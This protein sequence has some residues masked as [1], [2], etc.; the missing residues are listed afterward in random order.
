LKRR[1]YNKYHIATAIGGEAALEVVEKEQTFA[2]AV[3]DMRMPGLDG[4]EVLKRLRKRSPDTQRIMLT[5][6]IDQETAVNAVNEGSILRFYTKPCSAEALSE[7]ID[8]GIRQ[9]RLITA[10]RDLL[11]KTLAGSVKVLTDVLALAAPNAFRHSA[12]YRDWVRRCATDLGVAHPWQLEIA[13]MLS[14][15][16]QITLPAGLEAKWEA[17]EGLSDEERQV[18]EQLPASGKRLIGNIPRMQ[19][20]SQIVYYQDKAFDGSGFPHDAVAGKDIPLG[21]RILKILKGLNEACGDGKPDA[22]SFASLASTPGI[23]DPDLLN[24]LRLSLTRSDDE[25]ESS[26]IETVA[27]GKLREGDVLRM[28]IF[29]AHGSLLLAFGT[30]LSDTQIEKL[31]NLKRMKQLP[32]GIEDIAITR[33]ETDT[34]TE[35]EGAPEGPAA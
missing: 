31:H 10:E 26:S 34:E 12:R 25:G 17:G 32:R 29:D 21:A 4:L 33:P 23:Y 3:C 14:P 22:D 30:T 15:I 20:I 8:A 11:E 9:H 1:L 13:A 5:G 35:G 16:G 7:G 24:Q 28:D 18:I 2:V 19:D 6:N 27:I